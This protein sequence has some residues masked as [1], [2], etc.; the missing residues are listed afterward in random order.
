MKR[1]ALVAA[2]SLAILRASEP[3]SLRQRVGKYEVVLRPQKGGLYAGEEMQI[4]V[5]ISD[6]SEADP[7]LG[8]APVV[9]ANVV[10][11]IDMPRM[12]AMPR[13]TEAAHAE[14]VPGD[15]GV[16]PTFAHGGEYRL[17]LSITP[18]GE[19]P[20]K[21]EFP[22]Q[23][24]DAD[25]S[26]RRKAVPPA[27]FMEVIP[28]PRNPK[29]GEPVE[30]RFV[31][32]HRDHPKEAIAAFD[33]QHERYLHL[34]IVRNDLCCFSH[35]HPEPVEHAAFRI[36]HTF[37]QGGEYHLFAD[38]APHDAGSQVL[39][40]TLKVAGASGEKS[41]IP[42]TEVRT[43]VVDGV[44]FEIDPSMPPARKTGLL[45]VRVSDEAGGTLS[46]WEPYL[47]AAGHLM[48][49]GPGAMT[50]V[51]AHPD[52]EQVV[53]PEERK[54]NFLVRFPSA[55]PYKLWV[56]IQRG[57]KVITADFPVSVQP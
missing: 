19:A 27:Y 13:I 50:F 23:V 5:R 42:S 44:R 51:H 1:V 25:P 18:A 11:V 10:A 4:E 22:L 20:F 45:T 36:Q 43:R 52:G 14:S 28:A 47:G 32:H 7:I 49:V 40:A 54:V 21:V 2:L 46:E 9:R 39:S 3:S 34:V 29:A 56:Q 30:L 38:V 55:G 16:H 53:R 17:A 33:L 48:G 15:Y 6:A 26:R 35:V 12:Q 41:S 57:G 8:N 37:T 24:S 31:V